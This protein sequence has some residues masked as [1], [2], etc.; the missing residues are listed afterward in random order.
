[1]GGWGWV[2]GGVASKQCVWPDEAFGDLCPV[3]LLPCGAPYHPPRG[4][5][6]LAHWLPSRSV[7]VLTLPHCPGIGW[8]LPFVSFCCRP[9]AQRRCH[10][11]YPST[12]A[13]LLPCPSHCRKAPSVARQCL[14]CCCCSVLIA[15]SLSWLCRLLRTSYVWVRACVRACVRARACVCVRGRVRACVCVRVRACVRERACVCV[16]VLVSLTKCVCVGQRLQVYTHCLYC[17]VLYTT[18]E[19]EREREC[20][21]VLLCPA[22]RETGNGPFGHC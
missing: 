2:G 18:R 6:A 13:D 16:V 7:C 21:C 11:L 1:M 10:R 5:W 20:V 14:C 15:C 17:T 4:Y 3:T 12:V 8:A 22:N 9:L 19:R